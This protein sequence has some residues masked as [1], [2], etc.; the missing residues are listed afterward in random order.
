MN[1]LPDT[2]KYTLWS[3]LTSE[4]FSQPTV[5]QICSFLAQIK[6]PTISETQLKCISKPFTTEEVL[7]AI[8]ALPLHKS[9]GEDGF[10]NVFYKKI[11]NISVP[12]LKGLFNAA[13][14]LG[15]L[16]TDML[17]SIITTIPKP[18]NDTSVASNYRPISLLNPDIKLLAKVIANR[19][20]V[21]LPELVHPDQVEFV[22]GRQAPDATRR[23]PNLIHHAAHNQA[24]SL[25][26]SLDAEKAFDRVHWT[27]L[28]VVLTK[29]GITGWLQ[30]VILS[31]YSNPSAKVLTEGLYP[32]LLRV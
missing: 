5:D 9:P 16:P 3:K 2:D 30:D 29:F 6:L 28:Q 26:L 27:F 32:P 14:S 24:P 17:R 19:L 7:R 4:K 20:M 18:Q 22:P 31:L 12:K 11:D 25:L 23:V 13:G 15:S 1:K 21:F 8:S 10:T